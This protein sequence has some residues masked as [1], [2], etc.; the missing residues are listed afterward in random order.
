MSPA[1]VE[2]ARGMLVRAPSLPLAVRLELERLL[3]GT[4]PKCPA[5]NGPLGAQPIM[6]ETEED[7][8]LV[9]AGCARGLASPPSS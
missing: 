4:P 5:C 9:C 7:D 8:A 1:S 3:A 6:V 2:H